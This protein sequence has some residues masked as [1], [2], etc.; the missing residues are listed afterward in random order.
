[1]VA[2]QLHICIVTGDFPALT[3]TFITNKVLE[4]KK[5][6]HKLTVIKN[7]NSGTNKTHEPLVQQSGI[8]VLTFPTSS[9][10]GLLS[11]YPLFL[12]RSFSTSKKKIKSNFKTLVQL[13]LLQKHKYDIVH[14][15]FS[16]LAIE[17]SN[18]I[19]KIKNRTVV[20]CRGSAEKVKP[21]S[22]EKR[23]QN[24][25]I[26]FSLVDKIHCVSNDMAT[27]VKVYNAD[28][29]K[30]FINPPSVDAQIFTRTKSY[31]NNTGKIHILSIGRLTF[32]KGYLIGLLAI[33][34]LKSKGVDFVWTIV[35]DGPQKEE[36]LFHINALQIAD[37]VDLSGRKNRDEIIQM[38]NSTDIFFLPS[39]YEGIAN[40]CLEAMAMEI[41][42]VSSDCSGMSEA[43]THNV[44]GMLAQNYDYNEMASHLYTLSKSFEKRKAMGVEARLAVETNFNLKKQVD[45]F[46]Q[47]YQELT[48]VS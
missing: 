26:I 5:R 1:V 33:K 27:T 17:Y 10:V 13:S 45:V 34:E 29:N 36:L 44:H 39:V 9:S 37:V 7:N 41:P 6:G 19:R 16:G 38:Y 4:L 11:K 43:I 18:T 2:K 8:E 12:I 28:A 42:V 14:F 22:D 21:L 24:L 48:A 46:E 30:I 23:K 3:E 25:Q 31:N 32:Q 20:S 35:G 40:V 47:H 15:E